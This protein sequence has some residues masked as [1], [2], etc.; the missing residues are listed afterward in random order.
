MQGKYL[1][2]TL[3]V[4]NYTLMLHYKY[5]LYLVMSSFSW[6]Y[7]LI[8]CHIYKHWYVLFLVPI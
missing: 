3:H 4:F 1:G 2:P 8:T 7:I 5:I 6:A